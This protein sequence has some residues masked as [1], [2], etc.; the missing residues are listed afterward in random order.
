MMT[1]AENPTVR[2]TLHISFLDINLLH[3]RSIGNVWTDLTR[4]TLYVLLPLAVG[5]IVK[6]RSERW[7][8][9]VRPVV[10]AVSNLSMILALALLIGLNF[11]A[12]LGTFR[13]DPRTRSEFLELIKLRPGA[14]SARDMSA[15]ASLAC[16]TD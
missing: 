15:S 8:A 1:A 7:A 10:E 6:N 4:S 13:S 12:M 16:I 14:M 9:R 2:S 11:S 5:M 3:A